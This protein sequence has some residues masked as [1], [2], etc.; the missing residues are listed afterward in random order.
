MFSS[1]SIRITSL[2]YRSFQRQ[3]EK[4]FGLLATDGRE[5]LQE[6]VQRVTLLQVRNQ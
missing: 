3:F 5:S 1:G 4:R 2:G 6:V